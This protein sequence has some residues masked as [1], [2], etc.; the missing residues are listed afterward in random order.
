MRIVVPVH[1]LDASPLRS[2]PKLPAGKH[3]DSR[4]AP[5]GSAQHLGTLDA[6]VDAITL[7]AGDDDA[8]QGRKSGLAEALQLADDPHRFAGGDIE[9]LLGGTGFAHIN[10]SDSHEV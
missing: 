3:K 5:Q 7:D 6:Q 4:M 10:V 9:A 8:A 2:R 1:P